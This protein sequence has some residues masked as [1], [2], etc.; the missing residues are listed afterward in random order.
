MEIVELMDKAI[1]EYPTWKLVVVSMSMGAGGVGGYFL[2]RTFY[3]FMAKL[4]ISVPIDKPKTDE[5][6]LELQFKN[7]ENLINSIEKLI[8]SR[9]R[10]NDA[11]NQLITEKLEEVKSLLNS[12]KKKL[13]EDIPKKL[14]EISDNV[15][16]IT[17]RS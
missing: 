17:W 7:I 8:E 3:G 4:I 6:V 12:M 11:N 5:K 2:T 13:E 14:D 9:D 1:R 16:N 15:K 10:T